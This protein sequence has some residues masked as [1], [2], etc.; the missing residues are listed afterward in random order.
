M[1]ISSS[2]RKSKL[3]YEDIQDLILSEKVC[4]RDSSE[5]SCSDAALI[6]ETKGKGYGRNSS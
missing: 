6:L 3:K 2:T 1:A 5:A 4:K